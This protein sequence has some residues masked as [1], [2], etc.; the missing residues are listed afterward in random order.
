MKI[1][2]VHKLSRASQLSLLAVVILLGAIFFTVNSSLQQHNTAGHA[3]GTSASYV[4]AQAAGNGS[5]DTN[6]TIALTKPV[7][8]GDLLVGIFLQYDSTGQVHVSE[9]VNGAWTRA[10]GETFSTSAGDV[11]V[12]YKENSASSLSGINI[13]VSADNA[14]YLQYSV[15]DYSGVATS[16][17]LNKV[18]C[19]K[20]NGTS[21]N[22]GS[23]ASIP[24]GQLIFAGLQA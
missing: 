21:V 22:S 18:A 13:T 6:T 5:R 15:S 24:Q 23:I 14:T 19:S 20:G 8:K 10:S 11:A 2:Q 3:S 16:N 17:A 9:N 4:Q 1:P 12:Y 7:A